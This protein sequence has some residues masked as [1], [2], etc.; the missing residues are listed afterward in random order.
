MRLW[1][2]SPVSELDFEPVVSRNILLR[3]T[4]SLAT[5][6]MI[7]HHR[8]KPIPGKL[9]SEYNIVWIQELMERS[10]PRGVI[11]IF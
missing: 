7:S 2:F 9:I 11:V 4:W 1:V 3:H 5:I 6:Y 10:T 8:D